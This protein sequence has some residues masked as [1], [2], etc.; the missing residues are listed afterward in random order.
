MLPVTRLGK[1]I[2]D[3]RRGTQRLIDDIYA[4][5]ASLRHAQRDRGLPPDHGLGVEV[6]AGQTEYRASP[7][8][9]VKG[10]RAPSRSCYVFDFCVFIKK[11]KSNT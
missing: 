11:E 6:G 2:Y 10:A 7:C 8:L 5:W 3:G 1:C 9:C 4:Y